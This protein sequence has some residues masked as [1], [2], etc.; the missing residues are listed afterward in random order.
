VRILNEL[1]ARRVCKKVTEG[2]VMILMQLEG[3]LGGRA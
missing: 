2:G 1:W 3:P